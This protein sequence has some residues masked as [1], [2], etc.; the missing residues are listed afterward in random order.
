MWRLAG[1]DVERVVEPDDLASE[2]L[3]IAFQRLGDAARIVKRTHDNARCLAGVGA[4]A[5]S[6][7][8]MYLHAGY[9]PQIGADE[10]VASAAL[11][12]L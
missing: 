7:L 11:C 3:A 6:P 9:M 12:D 8:K 10:N 4:R 1:E 2:E 5:S